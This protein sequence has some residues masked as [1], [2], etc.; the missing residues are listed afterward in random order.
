[1]M[2]DIYDTM[3]IRKDFFIS[4]NK[5]DRAWAEWIAWQLEET[6]KDEGAGYYTVVLQAWDFRPGSNFVLEMQQAASKTERTI[7]ILSPDYLDAEFTQPEWAAAFT[8]DPRGEKRILLPVR[9][10]ECKPEG[11]LRAIVYIDLVGLDETAARN[12]LLAGGN[13]GRAKP[14]VAPGFPGGTAPGTGDSNRPIAPNHTVARPELYPGNVEVPQI[15]NV[16]QIRNVPQI[17]NVPQIRNVPPLNRFFTGRE[18]ILKELHDALTSGGRA[19]LSQPLA[20]SG[21]GGIGK[22]QTAIAYA[23]RYKDDYQAILWVRAYARETVVLDFAAIAELLNLPEKDEQDQSLAVAAVKRWLAGNNGWLLIFDNADQP[24]LI[25]EFLPDYPKGHIL[26]TSRAQVFHELGIARPVGIKEMPPDEALQFLF[27]RTGRDDDDPGERNTAKQLT[28]ERDA[29]KQLAQEL[30]YLPLAL[31]QAGAYI[32]AHMVRFQDYLTSYRRQRLKLLERSTPVAGDYKKS[33]PVANDHPTSVATFVTVATTWTMNFQEVEKTSEAAADVLRFSAFLSPDNIPCELLAEGAPQLGPALSAALANAN[34]DPLIISETLEP[35]TRY[36]LI[37]RDIYS[38][39]YTIHR[40]VQEVLKST[41]DEA[42]CRL[43]AERTIRALNQALPDPEFTNWPL[44]DRLLSHA[45]VAARIVEE[46][47][48]EFQEAASLLNKTGYYLYERGAQYAEAEPLYKQSLDIWEK[49]LGRDHPNVATCLNNL[50]ENYYALGQYNKAEPLFKR[51]LDILEKALGKDH[52]D[53]ATSLNDLAEICHAQDQY[54]EAEPLF[55]RAL[56]ISEKALGKDHPNVATCLN[57]LAR[58]YDDQGQYDK[59]EPLYKRALDIWEKALGKDH[60]NVATCLSNL[61]EL[62]HAQGQYAE[63]EPLFKRSLDI[64]EKALGKDHP[65]VA[66]CLSSLA[67]LYDAQGQY[68]EAE[69]LFKRAL[70]ISE[71]ALGKDHPNVAT[72]LNNLARLYDDQG[73]YDNAEPLFKRSLDIWK[74][75]L[76][77]NHPHVATTLSGLATLYS[78]QGQYDNAEPLFKRSLDILEKALGKD[79]PDVANSLNNLALLYYAQGQYAKAE[80]LYK[81]SLDIREKALGKDHPDVANS[82]NNLAMLYHAQGQYDKAEPLLK[83]SLDIMEKALGK[84]HPHVAQ[85]LNNLATLYHDQGQYAKAEPLYKRSLDIR[86]KALGKDH[87]HVATGLENYAD[88]LRKTNREAE[89][90]KMEARAKSIL[91][92]HAQKNQAK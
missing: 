85:S 67:R 65:N 40:L 68:A 77:Q 22:T 46:L 56:G 8:Q 41:M 12:A 33:R 3:D 47:R 57:N 50:A 71:K 54:A 11:L 17:Q 9:V 21:L 36:S 80:P 45:Q 35:L 64:L 62:Y 75:A 16:S 39:I 51:S 2:M 14:S 89:A 6:K 20:I 31:E 87:P 23:H 49:S 55:K 58:L 25:K 70:G 60:P 92:R 90:A 34:E 63:A 78:D 27:R 13:R 73:Q 32:M 18:E 52:P 10:R 19:A 29:A 48:F 82:L 81:R 66:T 15:Q 4:Y 43:W 86:E 1:M 28:Q 84:D 44:C 69:P 38:N 83:R 74:K 91:A 76:G 79:H 72:C 88:L 59:A 61:A 42:T 5:A 7:A 24:R 37:S 30:G 26:L 53:V